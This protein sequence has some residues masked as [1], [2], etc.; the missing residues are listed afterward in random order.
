M[1]YSSPRLLPCAIAPSQRA[2][3]HVS[4]QALAHFAERRVEQSFIEGEL[5]FGI[6]LRQRAV[7]AAVTTVFGQP[8]TV[9][10]LIGIPQLVG[11]TARLPG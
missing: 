1:N 8:R 6:D 3:P 11:L 10:K 9:T 5:A 2:G 7:R 4:S